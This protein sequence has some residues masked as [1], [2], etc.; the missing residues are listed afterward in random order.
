MKKCAKCG[1][2]NECDETACSGCGAVFAK[3]EE[4][5]SSGYERN[6]FLVRAAHL[7]RASEQEKKGGD[8]ASIAALVVP[9]VVVVF[10]WKTLFPADSGAAKKPV[11]G[12]ES[13]AFVMSQKFVLRELKAPASAKFPSSAVVTPVGGCA[14][15]VAAWV[16]SQNGFGAMVRSDYHVIM[17]SSA[18]GR[19]WSAR[20]LAIQ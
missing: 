10:A 20:S 6:K 12:D 1:E 14:Y 17:E 15:S 13:M 4:A 5:I 16:D 9:I 11:C 8:L 2:D 18:D 3:V 7:A 19:S